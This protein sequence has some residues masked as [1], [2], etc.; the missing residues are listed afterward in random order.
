MPALGVGGMQLFRAEITGPTRDAKLTPKLAQ[1][2]KAI[3]MIYVGLTIFC[4]IAYWA[5]GME[6]FDAIGYSFG[7]VSTGGFTTHDQSIAYFDSPIIQLIAVPFMLLGAVN[8]SLHFIAIHHATLRHYWK[9]V[10]FK[11]FITIILIMTIL[12]TITLNQQHIFN[13][14]SVNFVHSLFHVV[15][16]G[17]TTGFSAYDYQ[18]W[19]LFVPILLLLLGIVGGCSG[20]TSGGIKM[21]R[22]LLLAKQGIREINRL[23][24]PNAHY[25]IKFGKTP[26]SD[27]IINAIWGYLATYFALF[28]IFLILILATGLDFLSAYSA[29]AA[30]LSNIGPGL[31]KVANNYQAIN[32]SA[33]IILSFAMLVGRLELFTILVL[34]SPVYW[35]N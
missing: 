35:R 10:E 2:A 24:H 31:G 25:V 20:S 30:A 33:K 19:P 12:V 4:A 29:T 32:D 21:V 23:I 16:L 5:A 15:S 22:C 27:K 7:T 26:L 8:F 14:L 34:L 1:S 28:G 17:T 9:D 3:W 6:L 18:Q 11:V 13:K